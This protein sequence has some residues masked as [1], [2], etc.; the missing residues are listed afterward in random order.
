VVADYVISAY[1]RA[2]EGIYVNLFTPSE[3]SW[4]VRGSPVKLIQKTT[5]PESDS[6]ELRVETAAPMEFTIYV[7]VPGWLRSPAEFAV[8]GKTLS[9]DAQPGSFAAIHRRW[10]ANDA[11]QVR[12]PFPL[13]LEPIDEVH[14][15]TVALMRGPLMLVALDS[16]LEIPRQSV[17]APSQ[18]LKPAAHAPVTFELPR[19]PGTQRFVPFYRVQN[20]VYTTY[21]QAT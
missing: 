15:N 2:A 6:T 17:S 8:N 19:T 18:G 9:V 21:V 20:E 12:L 16:P 4:K 11:I 7:R 1:F 3:V 13:R 14:P 10:Q 5:Y